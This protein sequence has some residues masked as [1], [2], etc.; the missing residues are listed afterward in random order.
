MNVMVAPRCAHGQIVGGQLVAHGLQFASGVTRG[1]GVP[2]LPR[3][4]V[5]AHLMY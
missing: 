1:H 4:N 3:S 5:D 2:T